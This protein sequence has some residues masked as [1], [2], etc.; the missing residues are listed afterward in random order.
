MTDCRRASGPRLL[1]GQDLVALG[2][3]FVTDEHPVRPGDQA[4]DLR[5]VLAAERAVIRLARLGSDCLIGHV[6]PFR[7]WRPLILQRLENAEGTPMPDDV[8]LD[9][10]SMVCQGGMR[11]RAVRC[12]QHDADVV[13]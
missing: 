11:S 8:R 12:M 4:P 3:A 2:H 6:S 5:V 1:F 10:P 13:E 7:S 9:A